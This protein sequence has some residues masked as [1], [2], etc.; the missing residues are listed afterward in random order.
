MKRHESLIPLSKQHHQILITAQLIKKDA[1]KYRGMPEEP[2]EK[3]KYLLNFFNDVI[4]PH[5]ILEEEKLFPFVLGK[6]AA[7]DQLVDELENEH[8]EAQGMIRQI[9][10]GEDFIEV[11]DKLGRHLENHIR[12]EERILFERIQSVF[13]QEELIKIH[14]E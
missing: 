11:M 10:S 9:E 3:R 1:P 8:K 4:L 12:R 13:S 2:E 5:E 14:I 7:I 6:D